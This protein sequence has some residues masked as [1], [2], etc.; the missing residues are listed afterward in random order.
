MT[1][2]SKE[3]GT[4]RINRRQFSKKTSSILLSSSYR[5]EKQEANLKQTTAIGLL[6]LE[7]LVMSV[8][9]EEGSFE[10]QLG[11][12]YYYPKEGE[13]RPGPTIQ[14]EVE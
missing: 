8:T 5:D 4:S 14:M 3:Y 11:Y 2:V 6:H 12:H 10:V 9:I 1:R 13:S 7:D